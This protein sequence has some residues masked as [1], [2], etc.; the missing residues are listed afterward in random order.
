MAFFTRLPALG[1]FGPRRLA[2]TEP[3]PVIPGDDDPRCEAVNRHGER[4]IL[5][6]H[7]VRT[8]HVSYRDKDDLYL[9]FWADDERSES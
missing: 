5:C 8:G 6:P 9:R 4:C 1:S 7:D 3:H 2:P